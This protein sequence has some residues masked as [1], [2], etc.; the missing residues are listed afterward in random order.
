MCDFLRG[1]LYALH[2]APKDTHIFFCAHP[3]LQ[4]LFATAMDHYG[5]KND[6]HIIITARDSVYFTT[7]IWFLF[8]AFGHDPDKLHLMQG[9][10]E[11]W[12]SA[13]GEVDTKPTGVPVF[14]QMEPV[15]ETKYKVLKEPSNVCDM[16]HVMGALERNDRRGIDGNGNAN[17]YGNTLILDSRGSSFASK[18]HMPGAIHL[19]YGNWVEKDNTQKWKSIKELSNIFKEAGVDPATDQDIICTCG[20]GVSVCH[21]LLALELCGRDLQDARS[22][23]MYDGSWAEYGKETDTPKVI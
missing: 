1:G 7:R 20:S 14:Q 23:L 3:L 22:T 21:T 11:E 19:P 9:S 12:I 10:L 17:G 8:K 4:T 16:K 6:H 18:G 5:I 15:H 2:L 13:G